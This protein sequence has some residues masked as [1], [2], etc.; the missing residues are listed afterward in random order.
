[1]CHRFM[2]GDNKMTTMWRFI[3]TEGRKG[4]LVRT[5]TNTQHS[6][7]IA[8]FDLDQTIINSRNGDTFSHDP[9]NWEWRSKD[10]PEIFAKFAEGYKIVIF[11]NQGNVAAGANMISE[12]QFKQ[13]IENII[14]ALDTLVQVP[15]QVFAAVG[16]G[17]EEYRKPSTGLWD[18]M[19]KQYGDMN[20]KESFFCGDAAGR[21]T[22]HSDSDRVFAENIGL[23]FYTPE[24]IFGLNED[25][26]EEEIK[27][28]G[29]ELVMFCGPPACGKSTYA[30]EH[31]PD[32]ERVNQDTVKTLPKCLKA[33]RKA[34]ENEQS[35]VIDNMNPTVEVRKKYIDI[36]EEFN[37]PVRAIHFF[38][39]RPT[40]EK[41][42]K[43]REA[44]G[45]R[46]ISRVVY[47][48]FFKRL[49]IP[50]VDEGFTSVIKRTFKPRFETV[51]DEALFNAQK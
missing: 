28:V 16:R 35:C 3:P 27:V 9:D 7:L 33:C 26:E 31:F 37:V 5:T 19:C 32:Y 4:A 13:K 14:Q 42:S 48:V 23:K 45:G 17:C 15:V 21:D 47:N 43:Y 49:E 44:K 18:L 8:G 29:Q 6:G 51:E 30:A 34:L 20:V 1:M 2:L 25:K 36:A 39:Q 38:V 10:V 11:T 46:H 24:E 40:C 12:T 50:S 41:L 22:D